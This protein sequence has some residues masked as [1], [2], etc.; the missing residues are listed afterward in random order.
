[1]IALHYA[2]LKL[3]GATFLQAAIAPRQIIILI[4]AA[5]KGNRS[6]F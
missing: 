2:A 4:T 6:C 5:E 3:H 1:M